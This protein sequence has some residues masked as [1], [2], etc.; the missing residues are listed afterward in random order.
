MLGT[1]KRTL[2]LKRPF[3]TSVIRFRQSS[4]TVESSA[5][6]NW[7]KPGNV[8][9]YNTKD[10]KNES[11]PF[12]LEAQDATWLTDDL[13]DF[14]RSLMNGSQNHIIAY[15]GG[16]D[17]SVVAAL[18]HKSRSS[19]ESVQAVLGLSPAVPS[20]QIALAEEVAQVI[21]VPLEQIPTTEGSDATYIENSGQACLACKTHLYSCLES[22]AEHAS[23]GRKRLYNGTNA[24][25][26]QDPTRLGLIAADR[27]DVQS[28]LKMTT[29]EQVRIVGRHLGLPN[30]NYAA[31]PCLRSR[32]AIGV[33]AV[34]H[35]LQRIEH[36]ER[37]VRYSLGL[38]ATHNLRV[39]LL[40][41][42][43]AMVEV[44]EA[45]LAPAKSDL[46]LWQAYFR[47]NLEF[48]SVDVRCFKSGSVAKV[49][50]PTYEPQEVA[51]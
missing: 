29:K 3:P 19:E 10:R 31:S 39:R 22:I 24:D 51:I 43:R 35:H 33:E 4:T 40:S 1:M 14:T 18:V 6:G 21:G 7:T 32:L 45:F 23:N 5:E 20:D 36:A 38:D 28:P 16:I 50:T 15:S 49:V 9:V 11:T 46:E 27:F 42:N 34:P 17:S 30:W 48:A 2:S 8:E 13:L 12:S 41:G 47:D 37:H 44:E 25:D 26:L